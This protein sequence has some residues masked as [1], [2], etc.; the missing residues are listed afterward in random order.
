MGQ[1]PSID[2]QQLEELEKEAES[3]E[4]IEREPLSAA[5]AIYHGVVPMEYKERS[6]NV[7]IP[8]D[9]Y[10]FTLVEDGDCIHVS[11]YLC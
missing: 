5:L 9:F 2:K 7:V 3:M 10:V 6:K 4:N 11:P 1:A 8:P